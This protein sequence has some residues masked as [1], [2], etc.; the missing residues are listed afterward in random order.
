MEVPACRQEGLS[1]TRAIRHREQAESPMSEIK[2]HQNAPMWR[3][4]DGLRY[5]T[6]GQVRVKYL[7]LIPSRD[8]C[9]DGN[10]PTARAIPSAACPQIRR[11]DLQHFVSFCK[12]IDGEAGGDV[13]VK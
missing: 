12:L 10:R 9:G 13:V 3:E 4:I 6:V 5:Q 2:R 8:A 11:L 7:E 1:R